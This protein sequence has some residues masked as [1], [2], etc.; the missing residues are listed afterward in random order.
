MLL[1]YVTVQTAHCAVETRAAAMEHEA[2]SVEPVVA[3]VD[4]GSSPSEAPEAL[5]FSR[6]V[7]FSPSGASTL[8]H[9]ND[10]C[11]M[12]TGICLTHMKSP[13]GWTLDTLDIVTCCNVQAGWGAPHLSGYN[14]QLCKVQCC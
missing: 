12:C 5:I 3:L 8:P 11:I 13:I 9:I 2:V 7:A 14:L 6:G 4:R 1:G 10:A